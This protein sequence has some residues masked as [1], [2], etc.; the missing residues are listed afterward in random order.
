M[1]RR[2]FITR[3]GGVVAWP[4]MAHARQPSTPVIGY[5]GPESPGLFASRVSAFRDGLAETGDPKGGNVAIEFRCPAMTPGDRFDL[6][7]KGRPCQ[8]PFAVW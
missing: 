6:V 1:K 5:L 3:F 2:D 7:I 4:L 8:S